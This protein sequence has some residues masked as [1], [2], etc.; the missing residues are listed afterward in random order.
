MKHTSFLLLIT[1]LACQLSSC[2]NSKTN[3]A[4]GTLERDRILL[5]STAAEPIVDIR[6]QDGQPVKQGD[7]ILQLDPSNQT[8]VVAKTE[9]SLAL[10]TANFNKLK[11]G[12]RSEDI[13][14]TQAQLTRAQSTLNE[15]Q[16]NFERVNAMMLKKLVSAA[17]LDSARAARDGAQ[18]DVNRA[19][20]NVLLLTHGTRAE[21]IQQ[22]QAQVDQAKAALEIEQRHLDELSLRATRNG[23]L[24]KL[25]KYLGERVMIGETL[26]I[27][28]ADTAPYA[29]VYIPEKSR[30]SIAAG[31]TLKVHVDGVSDVFS[32]RVKWVSQEPAFTPYYALNSSDRSRLVYL[33]E[34]QLPDSAV[35]LPSGIPVQVE[36]PQ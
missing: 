28:L 18:A 36:L 21:D 2:D 29:R 19:T 15:A 31:M 9:A 30:A 14:A 6:I 10:A 7:L 20:Q 1:A 27:I 3:Q 34:I 23:R 13:A 32:S 11:N 16:K 17:N 33:A 35:N 24:D 8:Q 26:A 4:L 5:K 22:A 12:A 25:P